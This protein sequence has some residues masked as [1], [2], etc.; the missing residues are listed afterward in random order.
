MNKL[1]I[2]NITDS[3]TGCGAC[4]NVCPKHCLSLEPDKEGFYGP[5]YQD[6]CIECGMCEKVCHIIH[7][8]N[9]QAIANNDVYIYHSSDNSIREKSSSGGAFSLFSNY[10]IN[11]GGVVFATLYNPRIKRV[12]VSNSDIF[13]IQKFRK[14]KYVESFTGDTCSQIRKELKNGRLVL[15]CGTP[16]QVSGLK[17]YLEIV[18]VDISNLIT[19]DFICHGVPSMTCLNAFLTYDGRTVVDMDFR[20]KDFNNK[21]GWHDMAYCEYYSNGKHKVL[22]AND[23]H[24]YYY[25][26]PFLESIMLR[27]SCYT[28][29]E[30]NRSSADITVGDFWTIHKDKSII[31]DNKGVSIV[32]VHSQKAKNIWDE[33]KR[34]GYQRTVPIDI[35]KSQL[36]N[37]TNGLQDKRAA[38]FAEVCKR[39][40]MSTVQRRYI[41]KYIQYKIMKYGSTIKRSLTQQC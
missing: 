4:V 23:L 26:Y 40:Y 22:T 32:M 1:K 19:I 33:I 16:C 27:K 6:G 39:G 7:A 31:D 21:I 18:N 8:E 30:V 9:K 41:L 11:N 15:F 25:Y 37:K 2:L 12:E 24:Y 29:D 34:D 5:V 20:F 17:R 36:T 3:C 38:F 35:I 13:P 14:S 10:V 28:C